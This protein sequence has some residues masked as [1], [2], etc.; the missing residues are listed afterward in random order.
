MRFH[1]LRLAQERHLNSIKNNNAEPTTTARKKD[2]SATKFP[3]GLKEK[4]R[5]CGKNIDTDDLTDD[6]DFVEGMQFAAVMDRKRKLGNL[7]TSP[8]GYNVDTEM[9]SRWKRLKTE[10]GVKVEEGENMNIVH[11]NE[12]EIKCGGNSL[13]TANQSKKRISCVKQECPPST[14]SEITSIN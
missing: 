13:W 14:I 8:N 5:K 4:S 3:N 7:D 2:V 1:R 6:D 11:S 9:E 12:A 10:A